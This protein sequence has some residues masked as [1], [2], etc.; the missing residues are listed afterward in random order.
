MAH[1]SYM[2]IIHYSR[3]ARR[4]RSCGPWKLWVLDWLLQSFSSVKCMECLKSFCKLILFNF[5]FILILIAQAYTKVI[6]TLYLLYI[7]ILIATYILI[8]RDAG[9]SK[10]QHV[11]RYRYLVNNTTNISNDVN[12]RV[13]TTTCFGIFRPSDDGWNRPKHVFVIILQ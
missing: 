12:Q 10:L 8:W 5:V 11:N 2:C 13:I 1:E 6:C 3:A 9:V 4:A 7:N